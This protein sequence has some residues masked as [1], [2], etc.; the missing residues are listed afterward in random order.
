MALAAWLR[1]FDAVS[2]LVEASKR[3][4]RPAEPPPDRAERAVPSSVVGQLEARLAGVVVA[5][6]K[7][8]FDRDRARMDLERAQLD[9]EARRA[10]EALRLEARRQVIERALTQAR[11]MVLIAV[12]IWITS[13]VLAV[14]LPGMRSALPRTL[15][16][17]GWLL[18]LASI[19]AGL[20][21]LMRG[22]EP[23]REPA[24]GPFDAAGPWLLVAGFGLSAASVL[25]AL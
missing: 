16:G 24:A 18:L 9:A 8:A 12:A 15:L 5:A 6:L 10:E 17:G 1:M 7:E 20:A 21:A 23:A 2:G 3:L 11:L 14:A 22:T 13:A 25:A 19:A 4:R